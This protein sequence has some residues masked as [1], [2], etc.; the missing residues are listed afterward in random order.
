MTAPLSPTQVLEQIERL[1]VVPFSAP[2]EDVKAREDEW[3]QRRHQ[4]SE[5]AADLRLDLIRRGIA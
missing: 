5:L 4:I 2:R 3:W 1:A